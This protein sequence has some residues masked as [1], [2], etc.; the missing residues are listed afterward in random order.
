ME[1]KNDIKINYCNKYN[2]CQFIL[3]D[4]FYYLKRYLPEQI[5][6]NDTLRKFY[7][8]WGGS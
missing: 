1:Y 8:F 4:T 6:I 5:L 2:F 7:N 3:S